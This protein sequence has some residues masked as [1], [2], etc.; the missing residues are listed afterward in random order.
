MAGPDEYGALLLD[1]AVGSVT[2]AASL[3]VETHL[4]LKPGSGAAVAALDAAGGALLEAIVPTPMAAL[5][6][7]VTEEPRGAPP[8]RAPLLDARALIEAASRAPDGLHW[9]WRAPALRELRLPVEGASLI[10]LAGGRAIPAHSHTGDE[11][12]LV[13]RGAYAD[14]AGRYTVGDIAFAG[15]DVDHSP[16]V[17]PGEDCVCLVAMS[18]T[19][20]FHGAMAR[21]AARLMA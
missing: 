9:R 11:I 17:P 2:P 21:I 15:P 5:P 7:T 10:R 8:A 6:L 1:Y 12:T 14:Q 3:L 18:G 13:L 19:L 4:R 16:Q 20:R